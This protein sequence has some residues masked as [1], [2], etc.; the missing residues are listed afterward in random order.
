MQNLTVKNDLS[1]NIFPSAKLPYVQYIARL[2]EDIGIGLP[3]QSSL[4]RNFAMLGFHMIA[5]NDCV[6]GQV[7]GFCK[8]IALEPSGHPQQVSG[9]HALRKW[10][11]SR[12]QNFTIDCHFRSVGL[13]AP[14]DAYGIERLE[15][16][17][18]L[19]I[20]ENSTQA[21]A[22][23]GRAVVRRQQAHNLCAIRGLREHILKRG[24]EVGQ[25]EAIPEG[26]L[27]RTKYMSLK[28]DGLLTVGKNR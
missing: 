21:E 6:A 19:A 26:I 9:A 5:V 23:H 13:I 17:R 7:S 2:E 15:R 18:R 25:G 20:L 10:I 14:I 22:D 3:C 27:A 16:K 12:P 11:L 1:S 24:N 8:C 4:Y 28:V